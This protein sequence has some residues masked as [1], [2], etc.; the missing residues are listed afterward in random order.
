MRGSFVDARQ[1]EVAPHAA[2][3]DGLALQAA[4]G[5][6]ED[7]AVGELEDVLRMFNPYTCPDDALDAVGAKYGLPR[8]PGEPNGTAPTSIG[9]TDGNGYRGRL[10]DA[11]DAW[12]WAGTA[13]AVIDQLHA[14]GIVDVAVVLDPDA[15][16]PSS[17][18]SRFDVSLGPNFGMLAVARMLIEDTLCLTSGSF[19]QPAVGARV[20]VNVSIADASALVGTTVYI[21]QG[22]YY[23]VTASGVGTITAQ[24][25]GSSNAAGPQYGTFANAAP[26]T[27]VTSGQM[28]VA[29]GTLIIDESRIGVAIVEDWARVAVKEI[30]LKWKSDHGY[31]G[32]VVL[33][34]GGSN[35]AGAPD[36]FTGTVRV[37]RMMDGEFNEGDPIGGYDRS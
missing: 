16:Y 11:W 13:K 4:L 8:Y 17:W 15:G 37:G 25:M 29:A 6:D 23:A 18:F 26:T 28:I 2:G 14:F 22:G 32:H 35:P 20:T 7:A 36:W 1:E 3:D 33:L 21:G 10:C 27:T 24:N 5:R 9:G 19:T 34:W 30:V 31:P 12:G